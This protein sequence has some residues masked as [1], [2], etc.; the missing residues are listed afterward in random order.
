VP[1]IDVS[2]F[3]LFIILKNIWFLYQILMLVGY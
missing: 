1:D 2:L 3:V